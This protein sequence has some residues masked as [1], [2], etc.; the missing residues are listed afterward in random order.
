MND[1]INTTDELRT[2]INKY[3]LHGDLFALAEAEILIQK[4]I[5]N[6]GFPLKQ[7]LKYQ[8]N[9]KQVKQDTTL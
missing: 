1:E 7:Y 9:E 2:L 3:D 5:H 8:K 6:E 4:I